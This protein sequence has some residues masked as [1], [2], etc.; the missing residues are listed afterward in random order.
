[1][2]YILFTTLFTCLAVVSFSDKV[3]AKE[4]EQTA[5]FGGGCFWCMEPPFE[6]LTGVIEVVA[7]YSGGLEHEATYEQV[8]SG[9]TGHIEAVR[10]TYNPEQVS[11][12]TLVDTFWRQ[13]DPTDDGGQFADRGS[14]YRTAI[15]Y[16]SDEQK[17]AAEQSKLLL[18]KSEI[19]DKP[20]VTAI[21]PAQPFYEAEEYHQD[22]Y[23]KNVLHYSR[24]K[25]GSGREA[26]IKTV[27]I[28]NDGA[29]SEFVKPDKAELQKQLSTLQYNVTQEN[30]TE[31]PFKNE[32]WDNKEAGIYVDVVSGE[33][34]FS[35][36]DKF[37]SG[38]GWPSFTKSLVAENV[39]EQR[40]I[41]HFM[42]RTEV[43]SVQGDS[44]LGHL[45]ND[46]P[47]PTNMR[48][49]INSAALR[50]IPVSDLEAQGY[51]R[52]RNLFD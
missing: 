46:G 25:A 38:T 45:F 42:L 8:S 5:I 4:I 12:N 10:V 17:L 50:F 40:D 52:F 7:G 6:Q 51:G 35:S 14:H 13:I 32:Y 48:Y 3:R 11:Y 16:T 29:A 44:H 49:C 39:S 15:F 20:V 30:G 2:N 31:P 23:L 28:D 27:W 41:S 24:Y 21:L 19:F 47:P 34:L 37:R 33:P 43:R 26:F 22:Y 36:L 9:R 1:M 18:D